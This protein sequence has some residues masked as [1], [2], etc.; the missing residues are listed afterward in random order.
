MGHLL[1]LMWI[2]EHYNQI[3][4]TTLEFSN[5]IHVLNQKSFKKKLKL[6]LKIVKSPAGFK[7]LTYKF[8]YS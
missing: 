6:K 3:T 5:A 1:I 2:K 7:F 8:M 4:F